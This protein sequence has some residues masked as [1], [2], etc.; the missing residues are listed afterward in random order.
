[1]IWGTALQNWST[2]GLAVGSTLNAISG[3]VNLKDMFVSAPLS[4][5]IW[6][7]LFYLTMVIVAMK[8]LVAL[9]YDH[10]SIVKGRV[11]TVP[12]I[13]SQLRWVMKDVWNRIEDHSLLWKLTCC[14]QRGSDDIPRH[15][16][17]LET[18]M[19]KAN[20]PYAEKATIRK[21]VLGAK[22]KRKERDKSAFAGKDIS[23]ITAYDDMGPDMSFVSF[24][25]RYS[26]CLVKQ[27]LLYQ[28]DDYDPEDA[29]IAQLRQLVAG[30]EEDIFAMKLR[31][32]ACSESTRSAMHGLTR[33]IDELEEM[34][35]QVLAEIVGIA[36]EAGVP[37][38]GNR[39]LK[40][41]AA[42]N[43]STLETSMGGSMGGSM[44]STFMQTG[45]SAIGS[46]GPAARDKDADKVKRWH[47]AAKS[48]NHRAK[49]AAPPPQTKFFGP[50]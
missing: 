46:G 1:M 10:F 39:G 48:I 44:N 6:F 49:R 32:A 4:T 13:F 3:R 43:A 42:P 17:M 18:V 27:A 25:R 35:H 19:E 21:T 38:G 9:V 12:G 37:T 36:N 31:L 14:C 22:W 40:K 41:K 24:D 29:K 15:N 5:V 47:R 50:K 23:L 30:A 2:I 20:L 34:V 8:V 11:G 26:S 16:D 7:A 33:R 45:M 28:K